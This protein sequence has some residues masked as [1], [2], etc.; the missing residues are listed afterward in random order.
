MLLPDRPEPSI[1]P[2]LDERW[3]GNRQTRRKN[4]ELGRSDISK[5]TSE[6]KAR[7]ALLNRSVDEWN[8]TIDEQGTSLARVIFRGKPFVHRYL[9][10]RY[11]LPPFLERVHS[12]NLS[13]PFVSAEILNEMDRQDIFSQ[14]LGEEGV[15]GFTVLDGTSLYDIEQMSLTRSEEGSL[16]LE[17]ADI[18]RI[19]RM[20]TND[21]FTQKAPQERVIRQA[22]VYLATQDLARP[23]EKINIPTTVRPLHQRLVAF[24]DYYKDLMTNFDLGLEDFWNESNED[25]GS[26]DGGLAK[27]DL[28]ISEIHLWPDRLALDLRLTAGLLLLSRSHTPSRPAGFFQVVSSS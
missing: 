25:Y 14:P 28:L 27:Q 5:V 23:E 6:Y 15:F 2:V 9:D 21:R 18:R 22:M 26:T 20:F 1:K 16:R 11:D 12:A 24:F 10:E 19:N 4:K 8:Q 3:L 17:I 7:I 13:T